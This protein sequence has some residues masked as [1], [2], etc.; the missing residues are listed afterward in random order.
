MTQSNNTHPYDPE[1]LSKALTQAHHQYGVDP[2]EALSSGNLSS[3]PMHTQVELMKHLSNNVAMDKEHPYKDKST[4]Q[5]LEPYKGAIAKGLLYGALGGTAVVGLHLNSK[6]GIIKSLPDE[7]R[8]EAARAA[9][10][11]IAPRA[12]GALTAG[13]LGAEIAHAYRKNQGARNRQLVHK[14]VLQGINEAPTEEAKD[15]LAL[16]ALAANHKLNQAGTVSGKPT[17]FMLHGKTIP[18]MLYRHK[19]QKFLM[20][21][22]NNN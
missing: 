14:R 13:S 16:T 11:D 22:E 17:D 20:P 2:V 5:K 1:V 8:G 6:M 15:H 18:G 19:F 10:K 21:Q 7:Y 3:L 9:F 12:Y 4:L